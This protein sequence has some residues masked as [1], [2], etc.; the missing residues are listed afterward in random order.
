MKEIKG[1]LIDRTTGVGIPGKTVTFKDLAGVDIAVGTHGTVYQVKD[2]V[3][4][5][6]GSFSFKAELSPGPI[7]IGVDVSGSEKKARKWDEKA[8]MGLQFSSD[9]SRVGRGFPN[10]VVRGYL[11][12]FNVSIVSGHTFRI[13]KGQAIIDGVPWSLEDLGGAAGYDIAGTAN[14][15]GSGI[16]PRLDLVSLRQYKESA[17]GQLAGKQDVVVTPGTASNGVPAVPTGADFVAIPI[18]VLSTAEGASTKTISTANDPRKYINPSSADRAMK[19]VMAN[20]SPIT[21]VGTSYVTLVTANLTDLTPGAIYD[22]YINIEGLLRSPG[23]GDDLLLQLKI[24]DPILLGGPVVDYEIARG[25]GASDQDSRSFFYHGVIVG[26]TPSG[27][28]NKSLNFE[29]KRTGGFGQFD[30][31]RARAHFVLRPR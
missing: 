3:T 7:Q 18:A 26:F 14:N 30:I 10:G 1:Y 27:V 28:T 20:A 8:Q 6:D 2:A 11:N 12:E 4:Q 17:V 29:I 21:N 22:G 9:I 31:Y 5:A 15:P 25:D 24:D 23:V 13:G 19:A 16:N